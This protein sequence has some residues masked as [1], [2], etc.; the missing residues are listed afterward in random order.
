MSSRRSRAR[1]N[2]LNAMLCSPELI[3]GESG[4]DESGVYMNQPASGAT[5]SSMATISIDPQN[6]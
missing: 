6:R 1:L 3:P 4:R 5:P 2:V